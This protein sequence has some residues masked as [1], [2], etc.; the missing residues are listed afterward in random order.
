[1][2]KNKKIDCKKKFLKDDGIFD[3]EILESEL[4]S[5][6]KK[7]E[8]ELV[9][10]DKKIIICKNAKA[11]AFLQT[12]NGFIP[13]CLKCILSN[14]STINCMMSTKKFGMVKICEKL[15][16][17]ICDDLIEDA[18]RLFFSINDISSYI[19]MRLDHPTEIGGSLIQSIRDSYFF[20][21]HDVP[22]TDCFCKK[23]KNT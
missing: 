11:T 3:P 17:R 23:L 20:E 1:M 21:N 6:E 15:R 22:E 14:P 13:C 7:M 16:E 2:V 19:E 8:S 9:L 12:K 5:K 18:D 10:N 4:V